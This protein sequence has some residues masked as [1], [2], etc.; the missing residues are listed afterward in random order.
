M[1][2]EVVLRFPRNLCLLALLGAAAVASFAQGS[3]VTLDSSETVF[4]LVTA[5][6]ACGYDQGLGESEEVRAEVRREVSAA[7][8]GSAAA[9]QAHSAMCQFYRDHRQND[10][11]RDLA[12]YVSL[13]LSLGEPPQFA[14]NV[15]ESDLPPDAAYVLGIVPLL[16]DF[17]KAINLHDIWLHHT[18]QYAQEAERYHEPVA[19]M[20]LAT[21]LYL[22]M[23]L[24]SYTGRRFFV[25]IEPMSAP[26]QVNAR[27]YGADYF[28][29]V[30]PQQGALPLGAIR[31]TYLHYVLDPLAMNRAKTFDRLAPLLDA[32]QAAPLDKSYKK[33]VSL[34]VTES[35]IRAVE[36]RMLPGGRAAELRR[37]QLAQRDMS[38]GFILT[39]YFFDALKNF[40]KDPTGIK[41]AYGDLLYGIQVRDIT[42]E[43]ERVQFAKAAEPDPLLARQ[44][45]ARP[46]DDAEKALIMG[47]MPEAQRLAQAW[48][49]EHPDDPGHALFILARAAALSGDM[50]NAQEF[51]HQTLEKASEPRYK[52]WSHIY[53]GRL[54]D[55]QEQREA[56]LQEYRAALGAG[57]PAPETRAAAERGLKHPYEM[58]KRP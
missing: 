25:Y 20:L 4:D 29:V 35:L 23:P 9:Q 42:K 47:N 10:S 8:E 16:Q 17:S 24:S 22:K 39:E 15:P 12:Q 27:N 54:F 32:V 28:M 43:A 41:D 53:L 2:Q 6:N 19:N 45:Q 48:L 51:F 52:A 37:E 5:A 58:P 57:D 3:P 36:A 21:D 33:D 26:G 44:R 1:F 14:P 40:E 49:A 46:L 31:H 18:A 55:L 11:A 7:V 38:E 13:A 34:L 50:K 56:A 30:S